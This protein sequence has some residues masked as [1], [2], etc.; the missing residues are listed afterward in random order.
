MTWDGRWSLVLVRW[1]SGILAIGFWALGIY[2]I[3][4]FF[5]L[6]EINSKIHKI[7]IE[8]SLK[9]ILFLL[10]CPLGYTNKQKWCFYLFLFIVSNTF[11][12]IQEKILYCCYSRVMPYNNSEKGYIWLTWSKDQVSYCHHVCRQCCMLTFFSVTTDTTN[13]N[14]K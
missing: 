9:K 14:K 2:K 6:S 4:V 3:K 1:R 5:Y 12:Q 8:F 13:N 10:L 11:C 7:Q